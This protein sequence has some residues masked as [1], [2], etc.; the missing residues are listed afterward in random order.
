MKRKL[1]PQGRNGLFIL[2]IAACALLA[3]AMAPYVWNAGAESERAENRSELGFLQ[4]KLKNR[5]AARKTALTAADKIDTMYFDGKTEGL[6]LAAFQS[7]VGEIAEK[8]N[9]RV[10]RVQPLQS[11]RRASLQSL[12]LDV[13]SQGKIEDVRGFALALE[14]AQPFVFVREAKFTVEGT[15]AEPASPQLTVSLRLEA[16]ARPAVMQ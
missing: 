4:D 12:K 1:S 9:M 6:S 10:E 3:A 5:K 11:D 14:Q 7:L 8:N 15:A 16:Y 2:L 13:I